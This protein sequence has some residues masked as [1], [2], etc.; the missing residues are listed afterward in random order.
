MRKPGCRRAYR[1]VVELERVVREED[2][3][4]VGHVGVERRGGADVW[5]AHAV[6]GSVLRAFPDR[7]EA[8]AF[9]RRSGLPLLAERWWYR[10]SEDAEWRP[11]VLVEARPGAVTVRF[12]LDPYDTV[13]LTGE[14]LGRLVLTPTG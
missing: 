11:T 10:P 9:L 7:A 4:L 5:V 13:T 1:R 14:A 2:G 8:V 6:F 12:G 3:E